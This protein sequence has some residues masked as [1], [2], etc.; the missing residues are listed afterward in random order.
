[1]NQALILAGGLGTRLRPIVKT[2]PKPLARINNRPFL[3]YQLDFCI[4]NDIQKVYLSVGYL[5]EK[6]ISHFGNCYKSIKIDYISEDKPL[7]TGGALIKALKNFKNDF[8]VLNGDSY[9]DINLKK[10][11]ELHRFRKSLWS[12]ALFESS[13]TDRYSSVKINSLNQIL[14]FG[15]QKTNKDVFVN[16]GIYIINSRIFDSLELPL[17]TKIS[18][19]KDILPNLISSGKEI[20]GFKFEGYFTDIGIPADFKSAASNLDIFN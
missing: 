14:S 10:F 2:L 5:K 11:Y 3:E 13:D 15:N 6:I 8:F 20:Y 18:L 12:I 16:G 4:K 17:D 7:G 1:M 9:F 19:E